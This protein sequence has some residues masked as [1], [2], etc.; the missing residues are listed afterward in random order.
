MPI[1]VRDL[2][3]GDIAACERILYGLPDWFGLEES[4]R[5]HIKSLATS[6]AA[7]A[8]DAEEIVGFIALIRHFDTSYEINVMA[9]LGERHRQGVGAQL[10]RWAEDWCRARSIGWLHVKTRGPATPD[11][12]YARTRRFY[13]AMGY[14]PLF[15]SLALWGPENAALVLVKHLGGSSS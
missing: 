7:V 8:T 9:V 13:L 14:T 15:E 12:H 4:N 10:V 2:E 5:A 6:P 1:H 3:S 11:P